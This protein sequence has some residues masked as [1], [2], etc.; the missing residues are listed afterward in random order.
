MTV[1]VGEGWEEECGTTR[2]TVDF[3]QQWGTVVERWWL[4]VRCKGR[5]WP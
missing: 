1:G 3:E 2:T 4:A 5:Q